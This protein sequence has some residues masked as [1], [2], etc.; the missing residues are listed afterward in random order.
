MFLNN[1][2]ITHYFYRNCNE[3]KFFAKYFN[4][5]IKK[6]KFD[7]LSDKWIFEQQL[8][9]RVMKKNMKYLISQDLVLLFQCII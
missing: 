6:I 8:Q 3:I 4:P 2:D 5:E 7:D 1:R 9:F